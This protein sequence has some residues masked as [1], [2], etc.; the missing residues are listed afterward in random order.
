[1]HVFC[2][3]NCHLLDFGT[4]AV[5]VWPELLSGFGS[6]HVSTA[7]QLPGNGLLSSPVRITG[8][9][10]SVKMRSRRKMR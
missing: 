1:M 5:A 4:I 6:L 8:G 7:E 9:L 2:N 10:C 3:Q